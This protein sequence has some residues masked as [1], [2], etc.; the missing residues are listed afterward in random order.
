MIY[1]PKTFSEFLEK[2]F[3]CCSTKVFISNDKLAEQVD[4]LIKTQRYKEAA[5]LCEV[6]GITW[7]YASEM[8]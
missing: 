8:S 2:Y 1:E 4:I 7:E 3:A 6:N 5:A